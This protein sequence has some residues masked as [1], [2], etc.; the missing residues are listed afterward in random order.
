MPLALSSLAA[1][2]L[3]LAE[4]ELACR[5]RGLDGQE[6]ALERGTDL[7]A[8]RASGARVLAVRAGALGDPAELAAAS[9][10]LGAPVSV[11]ADAVAPEALPGLARV[12]ARAGGRL[13]IGRPTDLA[14]V[15]ALAGALDALGPAGDAAALGIAWELR[16]STERLADAGAVV[17]AAG[18]HL[19]VVRLHGGG[20][21]QRAQDG[22]GVGA[23][24]RELALARYAGPI[25]LC[26]SEPAQ[27]PA[28]EAWLRAEPRVRCGDRGA[29]RIDLD[30][31][32]VEPR[33]RLD[34]ILGAYRA[35]EPGATLHLTV[36]HDPVC[37]AYTLEATEPAGS[38][39]FR[40]VEDGP[41]VWRAEV[42]RR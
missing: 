35:L 29:R 8:V 42:T 38:F 10:R 15:A 31:R 21:E 18:P 40:T 9:A 25:V 14:A 39:E 33:D 1:P 34:T 19:G 23:V 27:L 11:A 20:P 24:L 16:P 6:L 7:A 26:P 30:V 32:D 37:M 2:G 28:W 4:R 12:F 22:R 41:E 17:F 13:L 5:R 36:D 3:T